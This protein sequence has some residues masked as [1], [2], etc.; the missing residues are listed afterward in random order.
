M[1]IYIIYKSTHIGFWYFWCLSVLT[2]GHIRGTLRKT[3]LHL[4]CRIPL[5]AE[6]FWGDSTENTPSALYCHVLRMWTANMINH[7]KAFGSAINLLIVFVISI[8]SAFIPLKNEKW[9]FAW[10]DMDKWKNQSI[11]F[12]S[13]MF[14]LWVTFPFFLS[15]LFRL[16]KN[17]KT[18]GFVLVLVLVFFFSLHEM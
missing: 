12:I 18:A 8:Q 9:P 4:S 6:S 16:K 15:W 11:R 5:Q 7:L 2:V 13:Q 10:F 1:L 17:K 3:A 14:L